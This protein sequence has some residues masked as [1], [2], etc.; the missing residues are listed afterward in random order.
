M[1]KVILNII[2]MLAFSFSYGQNN[3]INIKHMHSPEGK[4]WK[5]Y[6]RPDGPQVALALEDD[7]FKFFSN[8]VFKY[9]HSGTVSQELNNAR[10]KT[11]AYDN[12][13]NILSWEFYLSNGAIKKY[14]AELTY[15]DEKRAV[16]NFSEDGKESTI[17][18][19][20]TNDFN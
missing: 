12:Q 1:K 20:I 2:F 13:T 10:T 3:G 8:G 9:D 17:V 14:K 16:M 11:W 15:L 18:V 5:R 7:V 6:V 19:L 4:E